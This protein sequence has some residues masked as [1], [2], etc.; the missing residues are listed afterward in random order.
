MH[1]EQQARREAAAAELAALVAE[2]DRVAGTLSEL[3][4][5][6]G[7]ALGIAVPWADSPP[8]DNTLGRIYGTAV[9]STA[10]SGAPLSGT[11][12]S[13]TPLSGTGKTDSPA[14]P[15][16][17][18]PGM[19]LPAGSSPTAAATVATN[20]GPIT[21]T[22]SATTQ[23]ATTQSATTQSA[24]PGAVASPIGAGYSSVSQAGERPADVA[25]QPASDTPTGEQPAVGDTSGD[26][27]AAPLASGWHPVVVFDD[28]EG[29]PGPEG[30][31]EPSSEGGSA[32]TTGHPAGVSTDGEFDLKLEAWVSEGPQY[33]DKD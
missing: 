7:R 1:E 9:S 21:S 25:V 20:G 29:Q 12:L 3:R 6:L 8:A 31:E 5:S 24:T 4:E 13:G 17:H 10:L 18:S 22:P 16:A 15:L 23:S 2:R 11:P 30:I 27:S 19:A 33:F 32:P 28:L 14:A 26:S